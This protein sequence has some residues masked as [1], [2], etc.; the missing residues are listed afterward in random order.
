LSRKRILCFASYYLP[1]FKS[2]G[3]VRSLSNMCEWLRDDYELRIVTRDRDLGD[4]GPY[5][6]RAAGQWLPVRGAM[7][8]H[9]AKPHWAP[10]PIRRAV[11]DWN[12][13]LL[14]FQSLLD[15]ATTIAPL[16]LRR[17]GRLSRDIPAV[18]APRGE[19]SPDALSLKR[20][21][22]ALYLRW[23]RRLGLYEDVTWHA[24]SAAEETDIRRWAGPEA[25][26]SLA[27]NLPP[28]D[29]PAMPM[30]RPAKPA[31]ELRLVFL[32][33][34]APMKNLDGALKML[35]GVKGRVHFDIYGTQE[36]PGHWELCRG[37]MTRLPAHI[38]VDYRGVVAPEEV[39]PT[40]S[41]YHAFFFPT[42]GEN[43]GHVILEALLAGCPVL[44]SDRTPWKDLSTRRA[45]FDLPLEQPDQFRQAIERF[46]A[47]ESM[48]FAQWS[49]GAR[50]LGIRYCADGD[51]AR[52][53]LDMLEGAMTKRAAA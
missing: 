31:G 27:P 16:V 48:E 17:F 2:G 38:A 52:P 11:A 8:W 12:P 24:T 6:N 39:I 4:N 32:S 35:A 20:R 30:A 51:L 5:P 23:A 46:A 49:S 33:R 43:F 22:K 1:G 45:G 47:M 3:P 42:L 37:L 50:E 29:L 28:R 25:R 44:L 13:E 53:T 7:V 21:K 26:I 41:Q 34:I 15:P 9:L 19:F 40:L 36:D 10:G 18:V 14:Y